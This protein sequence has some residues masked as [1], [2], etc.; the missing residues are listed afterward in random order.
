MNG[1]NYCAVG[2]FTTKGK[3]LRNHMNLAP[4]NTMTITFTYMRFSDLRSLKVPSGMT[5][6]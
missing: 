4:N 6:M 5:E 3:M 1:L 2:A